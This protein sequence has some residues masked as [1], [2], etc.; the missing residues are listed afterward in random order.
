MKRYKLNE[1]GKIQ[2]SAVL[3]AAFLLGLAY[4]TIYSV[5]YT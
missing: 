1:R 3:L 4:G 2:L 5:A